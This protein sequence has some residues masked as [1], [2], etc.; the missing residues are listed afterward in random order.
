VGV[1]AAVLGGGL[2]GP[3]KSRTVGTRRPPAV[4]VPHGKATRRHTGEEAAGAVRK[5]ILLS[6]G[7]NLCLEVTA[8]KNNKIYRSWLFRYFVGG[9]EKKMGLGPFPLQHGSSHY[10]LWVRWQAAAN[11]SSES[12]PCISICLATRNYSAECVR[13]RA[14]CPAAWH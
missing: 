9:K 10:T 14:W 6:D 2:Q 13:D 1:E 5:S 11:V 4:L 12:R 8:G 7:N 3:A